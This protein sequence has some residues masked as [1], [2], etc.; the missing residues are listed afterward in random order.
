MERFLPVQAVM[1]TG[2]V[3]ICDQGPER[4]TAWWEPGENQ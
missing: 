1:T 3:V 4:V 2:D